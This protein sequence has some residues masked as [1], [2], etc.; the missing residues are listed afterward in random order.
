VRTLPYADEHSF[1]APPAKVLASGRHP[2]ATCPMQSRAKL[3]GGREKRPRNSVCPFEKLLVSGLCIRK[4]ARKTRAN[5]GG[6]IISFGRLRASTT[7]NLLVAR[8]L[9]THPIGGCILKVGRDGRNLPEKRG[10]RPRNSGALTFG[11]VT[12]RGPG[13]WPWD[14]GSSPPH[15]RS[16]EGPSA[17]ARPAGVSGLVRWR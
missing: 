6:G 14:V 2:R 3:I 17:V 5:S 1:G 15:T 8:G 10:R 9:H 4:L 16:I 7:V 13:I 12:R 11:L